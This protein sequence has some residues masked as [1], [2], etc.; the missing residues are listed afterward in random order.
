MNYLQFSEVVVWLYQNNA[1]FGVKHICVAGEVIYI[2]TEE[3]MQ[4]L[5]KLYNDSK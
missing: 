1:V 4:R 2:D 5:F 3:G